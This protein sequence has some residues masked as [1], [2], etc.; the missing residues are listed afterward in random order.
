M[1]SQASTT[2]DRWVQ[3][4]GSVYLGLD[5]SG[6]VQRMLGT[7]RQFSAATAPLSGL[8]WEDVVMRFAHEDARAGLMHVWRA[9]VEQRV[10]P[11]Y[12]PTYVPF[13][14][15]VIAR[16]REVSGDPTVR[17]AAHLSPTVHCE[18]DTLLGSH[19]LEAMQRLVQVGRDT[20]R[21]VHGPLTDQQVEAVGEVLRIGES[22]GRLLDDLHRAITAPAT[23]APLPYPLKTL[24]AF[25]EHDFPTL[26]RIQT[27]RLY[28][29]PELSAHERVYCH[30]EV[31]QSV[32]RILEALLTAI[33][34]QSGITISSVVTD[35]PDTARVD[36]LY[37]TQTPALLSTERVEP[38]A[39]KAAARFQPLTHLQQLITT[40]A[41]HVAPVHGQVW[42][43]PARTEN[44][45]MCISFMLPRWREDAQEV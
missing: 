43:E 13:R 7:L 15:G 17:Y 31:R 20:Y 24:F 21:G 16:L 5:A 32:Q 23:T 1:S 36:I 28:I 40:A 27:H 4:F 22:I 19:M 10:P 26:R 35:E 34:P 33:T 41:A 29:W 39:L 37:R 38:L 44:A 6:T 3:P 8:T 14:P 45:T 11:K 30:A 42:A 18:L 2:Q 25:T 12:W 9:V